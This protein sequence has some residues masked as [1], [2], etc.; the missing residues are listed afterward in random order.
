MLKKS[1]VKDLVNH[2]EGLEAVEFAGKGV[3]FVDFLDG[4]YIQRTFRLIWII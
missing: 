4:F 1:E 3:S 2:T